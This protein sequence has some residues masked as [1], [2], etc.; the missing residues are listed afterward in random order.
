MTKP[1]DD[2]KTVKTDSNSIIVTTSAPV[3]TSTIT[4]VPVT[5]STSTSTS[6]STTDSSKKVQFT[7][8]AGVVVN[9]P[10][11]DGQTES[12]IIRII[13]DKALRNS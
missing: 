7:S 1:S 10:L 4:S 6:S 12:D 2:E 9:L 11:P 5:S 13:M 8:A 3:T